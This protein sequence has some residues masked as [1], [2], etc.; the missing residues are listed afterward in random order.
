MPLSR[1]N[2]SLEVVAS[3]RGTVLDVQHLRP[4]RGPRRYTVGEGDHASFAAPPVD[5]LTPEGFEL[6]R[7]GRGGACWIRFAAS[8]QGEIIAQGRRYTLEEWT[9]AGWTVAEDGAN[10]TTLPPG[11]RCLIRHGDVT[12]HLAVV[13][14]VAT[15]VSRADPDTAFW[16][17]CAAS[18]VV[19]TSL[20]VL[21][22]FAA[23][24]STH[25]DLEQHANANRFVGYLQ[26]ADDV[27]KPKRRARS[28]QTTHEPRPL[29]ETPVPDRA[30]RSE[31][32]PPHEAEPEPTP[33]SAVAR[34]GPG[35]T[36]R[37]GRPTRAHEGANAF[38]RHDVLA[39]AALM[40]RGDDPIEGARRAGVLALVDLS[41]LVN[42]EYAGA[43]SPGVDDRAMWDAQKASD[44]TARSVAGLDLTG[45]GR[46]GGP[47]SADDL[48]RSEPKVAA[49][50]DDGP[51]TLVVRAGSAKVRG[52]R[53]RNAVRSIVVRHI[54][55]L[56]RCYGSGVERDPELRGRITLTL[57]IDTSG[58]VFDASASRF[59]DPAVSDC[60]ATTAKAWRFGE[61]EHR[62]WTR[63][64]VPLTLRLR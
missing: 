39:A 27:P 29:K 4:R 54:R 44:P 21:A 2:R 62:G 22:H 26:A 3:Y 34:S 60:M 55:D 1:S 37:S 30:V 10:G 11:A 36:R 5:L 50:P 13:E 41:P 28:P 53:E 46:G 56:R 58:R 57:E 45:K 17:S 9:A 20:L 61:V 35:R 32:L 7:I 25:L 47:G 40:R 42:N 12:F 38:R 14:S 33:E 63:A 6:A 31:P 64:T 19:L 51:R 48:V 8:M 43:F 59:D 49:Q 16:S 23:P 18:F 15:A 24:A 52:P